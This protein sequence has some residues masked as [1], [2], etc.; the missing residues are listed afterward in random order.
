MRVYLLCCLLIS[1]SLAFD[2]ASFSE[3]VRGIRV[4]FKQE[5]DESLTK[6]GKM[7]VGSGL[8]PTKTPCGDCG[9]Y[10]NQSE[11]KALCR[12]SVCNHLRKI[13]AKY[14][15]VYETKDPIDSAVDKNKKWQLRFF[16]DEPCDAG[17][18]DGFR[19]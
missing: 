1:S 17:F 3:E 19:H 8:S 6:D 11:D 2:C 4:H 13:C 5:S 14:N 18:N 10:A 12:P 9:G 16:A 15:V 7:F